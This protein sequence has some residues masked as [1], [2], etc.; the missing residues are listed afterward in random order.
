M[1]DAFIEQLDALEKKGYEK[2]L[3]QGRIDGE[4]N[5]ALLLNNLLTYDCLD[6]AK[7]ACKDFV[8]CA[9]LMK[10]LK[11]TSNEEDDTQIQE[12][13]NMVEVLERVEKYGFSKGHLQGLV[14]GENK[15]A[16]LMN[17][18]FL[19]DRI[20]DAIKALEDHDYRAELMK[21]FSIETKLEGLIQNAMHGE[22]PASVYGKNSLALLV[23]ILF[24]MNRID[25][26][27]RLL[28][29]EVYCAELMKE[30]DIIA[31]LN[32]VYNST[33]LVSMFSQETRNNNIPGN[34]FGYP[35]YIF[36]LAP[37]E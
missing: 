18:M 5:L 9:H 26:I 29:D 6:Q 35:P 33:Q 17:E 32:R 22:I 23:K 7:K 24:D 13:K 37:K 20:D 27:K 1:G 25:D 30:M 28:K 15:L 14:D 3:A 31:I 16:L 19:L 4:N 11:I 36:G 12:V 2:G 10:E 21:E 34:I 8:Y